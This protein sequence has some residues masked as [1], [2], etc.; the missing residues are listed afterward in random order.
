MRAEVFA[1]KVRTLVQ[2][3]KEADRLANGGKRHELVIDDLKKDSARIRLR[4]KRSSKKAVRGT[5]SSQLGRAFSLVYQGGAKAAEVPRSLV[6]YVSKL[7][8]G[9]EKSFSHAEAI[10]EQGNV[11]R[12]DRFFV[13]RAELARELG[14][15]QEQEAAANFR[16][17]VRDTFDGR[18]RVIDTRGQLVRAMLILTAGERTIDC[19]MRRD[20]LKD[21][22]KKFEIRVIVEGEAIYDS[23]DL[24]PKRIQVET[25]IPVR[26]DADLE[27]WKGRFR[28]PADFD[29]SIWPDTAA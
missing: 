23:D 18:L 27:R 8:S 12:I 21:A 6:T 1:Q 2:A 11:V 22:L 4:E 20:L 15:E 25:I 29:A 13:E 9:A 28:I 16:G 7:A 5:G 10:Y 14:K 3:L 19:V 26:R 17:V 24:L